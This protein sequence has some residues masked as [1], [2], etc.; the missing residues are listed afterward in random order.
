LG[1]SVEQYKR[2]SLT[3]FEDGSQLDQELA[4]ALRQRPSTLWINNE[5]VPSELGR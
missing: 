5:E 1:E 3:L 2:N 4:S